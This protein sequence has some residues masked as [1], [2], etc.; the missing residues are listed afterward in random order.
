MH[1]P[2]STKTLL[3]TLTQKNQIFL[4]SFM[5]L[6]ITKFYTRDIILNFTLIFHL[7]TLSYFNTG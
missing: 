1:S 2:L 3:I 6:S 7:R 5:L 4:L